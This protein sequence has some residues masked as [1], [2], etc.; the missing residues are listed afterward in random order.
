MLLAPRV[1]GSA[2]SS[3]PA[4]F[5]IRAPTRVRRMAAIL[6]EMGAPIHF[7]RILAIAGEGSVETI[8]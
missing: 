6:T 2:P 3:S 4:I 8:D 1:A 5:D 7:T